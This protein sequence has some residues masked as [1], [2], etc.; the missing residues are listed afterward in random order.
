MILVKCGCGCHFSFKED[1]LKN[2]PKRL[3]CQN[4]DKDF[5][6]SYDKDLESL[7]NNLNK[8]GFQIFKVSDETEISFHGKL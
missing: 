1:S 4:C 6:F 3:T 2:R 8:N 5:Y 7:S